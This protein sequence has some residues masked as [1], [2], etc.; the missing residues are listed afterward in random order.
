MPINNHNNIICFLNAVKPR[1]SKPVKTRKINVRRLIPQMNN[2]N[3]LQYFDFHFKDLGV[4]VLSA[5]DHMLVF[6]DHQ[7]LSASHEER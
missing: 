6:I 4:N 5:S 1:K 3:I 2:E 7:L